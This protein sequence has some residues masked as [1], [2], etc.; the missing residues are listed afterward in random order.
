MWWNYL[1]IPKVQRCNRW[2]LGM[3]KLFHPTAYWPII[4]VTVQ[5]LLRFIEVMYRPIR[6]IFFRITS[7]ISHAM[8]LSVF[9]ATLRNM[10]KCIT[11]IYN[12]I[13][14]Q[15]KPKNSTNEFPCCMRFAS[16]GWIENTLNKHFL[17]STLLSS[18]T[19]LTPENWFMSN[20]W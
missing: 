20:V 18:K 8:A 9:K 15:P 6:P 14:M 10:A 7:L 16:H 12:E 3:D 13:I 2:S 4:K 1:S 17:G 11:Q 19:F 5:D